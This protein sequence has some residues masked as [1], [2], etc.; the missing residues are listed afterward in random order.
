MRPQDYYPNDKTPMIDRGDEENAKRGLID[1]TS[2]SYISDDSGKH[3]WDIASFKNS[4]RSAECPDTANPL[5]WR[6]E[7]LNNINGLFKVLP[8]EDDG[9]M[10]TKKEGTIYQ[11]RSYDLATMSFVKSANGWIVIDPLGCEETAKCAIDTFK[12]KVGQENLNI[13]AVLITHSHVDHYNG[14]KSVLI[15]NGERSFIESVP[16]DTK[17]DAN[18]YKGTIVIAPKGFYD[19]AISENLYLGNTMSRRAQYMYGTGLEIGPRGTI[20]S[21]LGKTVNKGS[22]ELCQ[23]SFELECGS[24]GTYEMEID[25]VNVTFLD[26]PGSEAPAEFHIYFKDYEALCP[27]ENATHTLH[28][29]LTSRGAKVRDPKAF[30]KALDTSIRLFGEHTQVIIGTHHWPVWGKENCIDLLKKERDTYLFL[31]DQVIRLANKGMNMEEIAEV[32]T[33]PASLNQEYYNRG[34]YGTLNHD[35]KAVFQRY[36]GWWDGNP[37]NYFKY[38]ETEA[39]SRF[40]SDMGGPDAVF[41]K[42]KEYYNKGDYRWTLELTKQILFCKLADNGILTVAANL[43]AD[44]LEQLGFSFESGTWRNIFLS[45]AKDLRDKYNTTQQG[46]DAKTAFINASADKIATLPSDYI[47]DYLATLLVPS[48]LEKFGNNVFEL[49]IV[50]GRDNYHINF[51]NS[52]LHYD[53]TTSSNETFDK[54]VYADAVDFSVA[55]KKWSLKS[56]DDDTC[57]E[58]TFFSLFDWHDPMWNIVVPLPSNLE[59]GL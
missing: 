3:V 36:V 53:K 47:F 23:P 24:D 39:A 17:Y 18:E 59:I 28:N 52:V 44:A 48:H 56:T 8:L 30:A 55:Y 15:R 46:Y 51:E 11:I 54:L 33:L 32:F 25:G 20:G 27:G 37:V 14:L 13:V 16:Q 45:G 22:G 43:H 35:S 12:K 1:D 7:R 49:D 4:M 50:I 34:Y 57:L 5:L 31:N 42:A 41:N 21:G 19:E 58:R 40:V 29:L 2:P 9:S 26:A 6:M 10:D 38:P